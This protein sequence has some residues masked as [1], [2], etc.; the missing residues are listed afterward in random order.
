LP[1]QWSL[2]VWTYRQVTRIGPKSAVCSSDQDQQ[3]AA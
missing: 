1:R 3:P 2:T